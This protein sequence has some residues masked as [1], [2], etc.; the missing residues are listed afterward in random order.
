MAPVR[1]FDKLL[2]MAP[3]TGEFAA[4]RRVL[5]SVTYADGFGF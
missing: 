1:V 2:G 4:R 3:H 5:G